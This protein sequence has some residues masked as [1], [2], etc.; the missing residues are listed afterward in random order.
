MQRKKLWAILIFSPF[1]FSIFLVILYRFIPIPATALML[2]RKWDKHYPIS[3]QWVDANKMSPHIKKTV[4]RSE[5]GLF[6]DHF[7]FDFHAIKKA[8][9]YNKT[10]RKKKGASTISQQTAKNVF[11]WPTRT[12]IRK[13]FE[14]YFTVLIEI[15]WGKNRIM[16]VYLNVI[17]FGPGIYGVEK[18]SQYFFKHR[19]MHLT[20]NEAALLTAVLP[21]PLKYKVNHPS[22]YVIKRKNRI[23][24]FKP[25]PPEED[26][27]E[28]ENEESD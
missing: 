25:P 15:F 20:L 21:N 10:H 19:A 18:A 24:G 9:E 7:G 4:V 11:L 2:I 27:N 6:Y 14:A 3:Y 13:I 12:Y 23:S 1:L 26:E 28:I 16:E 22:E 8:Q 17:E 5:D